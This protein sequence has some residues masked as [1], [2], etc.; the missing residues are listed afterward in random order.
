MSQLHTTGKTAFLITI[1]TEGDNLWVNKRTITTRNAAFL[2]RFQHLCDSYGLQPTYLTNYE[3]ACS[4]AFQDFGREV[5]ARGRGEIGMHLHAWNT[6]PL[7][8]LTSDDLLYQPF[9][10][11]YAEPAMKDKVS[12]MTDLLMNVF[13]VP[14]ISHRAGRWAMNETYARILV[15]H[16]YRVDC[17]VT[18]LVSW[19]TT[20]GDPAQCG[21][22]DY[23]EFPPS[24]Y[25][26]D[27]DDISRPGDSPLLELPMTIVPSSRFAMSRALRRAV[28]GPLQRT[29]LVSRALNRF[30]PV[31]HWL[32]P[33]GRNLD[34]LVG[35]VT[36]AA[37]ERWSYV[38]FMLHSSELMPGGSPT[39][40]CE[41]D[42]ERLYEDLEMLFGLAQRAC[43]PLT[44][45]AYYRRF[46]G[47]DR[48]GCL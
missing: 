5:I 33:S 6:P 7:R 20:R 36:R 17:S 21:G 44:L 25:F 47:G 35:I 27:V 42:V 1:D 48:E 30:F 18:P 10:I 43:T 40:P 31:V 34:A 23:S 2:A 22:P 12:T 16:G 3:M 11:E 14:M 39:F 4:P 45:A 46:T 19:R 28:P 32:R 9:L 8:P 37:Q 41:R 29:S 13:Q 15:G 24:A 26:L 38:E